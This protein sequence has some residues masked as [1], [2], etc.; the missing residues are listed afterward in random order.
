MEARVLQINISKGGV[1]KT[2]IPLANVGPLGIAGDGHAHPEFHGGPKQAL[3]L[4]ASEVLDVLTSEGWPVFRG[5]LG[6]NLTTIGLDHR[7]W[8]AGMRFRIGEIEIELTTPRQPCATLNRYGRG[9]QKRIY[10]KLVETGDP[11]SPHWGESGFYAAVLQ[12]GSLAENDT[13]E[14]TGPR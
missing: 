4:I 6:E 10:D 13:I 7:A 14:Y 8:R 12:P 2:P 5:A 3:L 11:T 1:P 9:I